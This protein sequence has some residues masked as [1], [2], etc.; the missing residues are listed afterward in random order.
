MAEPRK[1]KALIVYASITGNTEL[2]AMRFKKVFEKYGWQCDTF[3][4]TKKTEHTNLPY[5]L[6]DG[7]DLFLVGGPIWSGIPP[8]YLYDDRQGVVQPILASRQSN[9]DPASGRPPAAGI[10]RTQKPGWRNTRGIAFVTYAG[11]AEGT[12]EAVPALDLLEH[13]GM[14][15]WGIKC[16][17]K[18]AC[19]GK[20]WA[21]R[22]FTGLSAK[23]GKIKVLGDTIGDGM[24]AAFAR[25]RENPNSAEFA[26]LSAEDRKVFDKAVEDSNKQQGLKK[27]EA[28]HRREWHHD[29]PH[30]P[31]E[32]DLLKADIFLSEIIEDF[33]G[34]APDDIEM[35]PYGQN[36]CIS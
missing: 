12:L 18:F 20:M 25:Y 26:G 11:S 16:I 14:E 3:K 32:R 17:G 15:R 10:P 4:C 2:V 19:P 6:E 30:R 5:H 28:S 27:D 22:I 8:L 13:E 21:E 24:M 33:Y 34:V 29:L 35:Y 1:R 23:M 9:Y 31:N 36:V 7:Y